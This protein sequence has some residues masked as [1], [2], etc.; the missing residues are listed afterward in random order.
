MNTEAPRP[1]VFF[2]HKSLHSLLSHQ[3]RLRPDEVAVT[4]V[5]G[6]SPSAN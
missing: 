4:T 1:G 5:D 3:V 2:Q 6:A